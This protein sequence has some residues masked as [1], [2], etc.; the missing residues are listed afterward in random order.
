[1]E[2]WNETQ[3]SFVAYYKREWHK[4]IDRW[5]VKFRLY[6]HANQNTN[7]GIERWHH[8][9]KVELKADKTTVRGR[10]IPWLIERLKAIENHYWCMSANKFQGRLRNRTVEQHV[11]KCLNRAKAIPDHF[12]S[13]FES[14]SSQCASVKSMSTKY[15]TFKEHVVTDWNWDACQ[16]T[17]GYSVKGNACKHQ[18]L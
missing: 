17:C 13:L 1:M 15:T 11:H 3:P 5:A 18:V 7:G 12:V 16:C 6:N 2:K 8:T 14:G 4:K 10:S 9:L